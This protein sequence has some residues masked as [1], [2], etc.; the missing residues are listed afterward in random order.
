MCDL[1]LSA[2]KHYLGVHQKCRISGLTQICQIAVCILTSSLE[3]LYAHGEAL[4]QDTLS[5]FPDDNWL[6]LDLPRSPLQHHLCV[7]LPFVLQLTQQT[8]VLL[9]SLCLTDLSSRL[10]CVVSEQIDRQQQERSTCPWGRGTTKKQRQEVNRQLGTTE[11][12]DKQS[13]TT[14]PTLKILTI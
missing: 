6:F 9:P 14:Q 13:H 4:A 7:D 2:A 5:S 12:R 10:V 3:D 11:F 8:P 1:C